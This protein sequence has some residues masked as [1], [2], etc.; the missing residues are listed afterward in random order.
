M[1]GA[2]QAMRCK[3]KVRE[4]EWSGVAFSKGNKT[5]DGSF[6]AVTRDA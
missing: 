4:T 1:Q 5:V 6:I 3:D 2:S